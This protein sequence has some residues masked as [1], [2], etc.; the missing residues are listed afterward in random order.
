MKLRVENT[1]SERQLAMALAATGRSVSL[2]ELTA[3]RKD[4]LLPP[5]ANTGL[6]TGKGKSYYWR[7]SNILEQ[8]QMV[9]DAMRSHG[10][11]DQALV[12][13]FLSGFSVPLPQLRRAWLH[14]ARLRK[15]PAVQMV[16]EKP[17]PFALLDSGA[18]ALLLQAALCAG[19]ALHTGDAT[20]PGVME[21]VLVRAISKTG[22]V[23]HGANDTGLTGQLAH[24]L[25][26]IGSVL[27]QSNLIREAADQEIL[28]A[29]RY[30]TT[31]ANY[32]S[33]CGDVAGLMAGAAGPLF[34]ILLLTLLH[35]GQ[36]KLLHRVMAFL[37][38]T[39]RPVLSRPAGD[40]ALPA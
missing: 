12:A 9:C 4:G 1:T 7:E 10:R 21:A 34:F 8:A 13:L 36:T 24:L 25:L 11:K 35:S 3:W 20:S 37:G 30:L 31:V 33:D 27:D 17:D 14:R 29:Q 19:T 40:L 18:D 38:G 23:Q 39:G 16:H 28:D 26:I 6:G 22:M 2:D 5:M 32:L 15:P